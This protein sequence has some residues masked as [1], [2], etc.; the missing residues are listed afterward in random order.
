MKFIILSLLLVILMFGCANQSQSTNINT[1]L[2]SQNNLTVGDVMK[3]RAV[4]SGDTVLVDYVGTLDNGTVFDTSIQAVA[5]AANLPPHPSYQPFNFVVGSGQVIAG[6]DQG[7]IGMKVNEEKTIHIQAKDAY[8]E[9]S[10]NYIIEVP[11]ANVSGGA[12][13]TVGGVIYANGGASQ[14]FITRIENGNATI[15][16]NHPLAGKALNF[17]LT[18]RSIQ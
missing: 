14:G 11:V 16:F 12:N 7:V 2:S 17:K 9:I 18:L 4:Q 3:D 15:D 8:G 1:T 13:L 10:S 6:F 5:Q